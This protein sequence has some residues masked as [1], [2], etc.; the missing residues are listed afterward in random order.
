MGQSGKYILFVVVVVVAVALSDL[1]S[2]LLAP[3]YIC[4]CV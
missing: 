2:L 1:P 3:I 4:M